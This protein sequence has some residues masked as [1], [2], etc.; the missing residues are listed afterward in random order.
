VQNGSVDLPQS[1]GPHH[2]V[3]VAQVPGT[4]KVL[5]AETIPLS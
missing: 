2:L 5:A 1:K 3:L 4:G